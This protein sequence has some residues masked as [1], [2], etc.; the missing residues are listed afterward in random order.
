[1]HSSLVITLPVW[2][3]GKTREQEIKLGEICERDR[4][5]FNVGIFRRHWGQPPRSIT[6][7]AVSK[8]DSRVV[9]SIAIK[10]A[11]IRGEILLRPDELTRHG[12]ERSNAFGLSGW[13]AKKYEIVGYGKAILNVKDNDFTVRSCT[14]R[15]CWEN[16]TE[17]TGRVISKWDGV[18]GIFM[19]RSTKM[20]E[21][22]VRV[23]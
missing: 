23:L 20:I 3:C 6:N 9:I 10:D 21:S 8:M 4:P 7:S 13:K 18:K 17:D 11:A 1:M 16:Q 19:T 5:I 22:T 15:K 12:G 2:I 14:R